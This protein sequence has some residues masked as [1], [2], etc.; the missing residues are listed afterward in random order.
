MP[1]PN[2]TNPLPLTA[3]IIGGTRLRLLTNRFDDLTPALTRIG[4]YLVRVVQVGF[5]NQKFGGAGEAWA[6]RAVPNVAGVLADANRGGPIQASR[7]VP[8]PALVDTG[9]LRRSIGFRVLGRST[10]QV[11]LVGAARAYGLRQQEG[12]P[13]T[14]PVTR[15]AKRVL[16]TFLR[17][18]KRLR[19]SL[20]WLFRRE[21]VTVTPV[22][23]RFLG[24]PDAARRRAVELALAHV[25]SG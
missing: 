24:I 23:R 10:V 12:L 11:E 21:T 18:N 8:R 6:P 2:S 1:A 19:P 15:T 9:T 25:R 14:L 5:A 7:F 22:A 13:T 16:A 20:G 3:T 17:A 4:Q